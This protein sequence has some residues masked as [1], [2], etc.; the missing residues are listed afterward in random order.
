MLGVISGHIIEALSFSSAHFKAVLIGFVRHAVKI[1]AG[2][3]F[4]IGRNSF[5]PQTAK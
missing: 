1:S 2:I 5:A 3:S 4:L